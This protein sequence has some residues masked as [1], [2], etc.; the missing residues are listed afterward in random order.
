V[1]SRANVGRSTFYMHFGGKDDLLES[2][3]LEMVHLV[4]TPTSRGGVDDILAFSLPT[5]EHIDRHRRADGPRMSRES[6]VAMHGR[7]RQVPWLLIAERLRILNR[8]AE[9]SVSVP[10]DL[11]ARF[12]A[13]TFVLVLDWWVERESGLRPADADVRFRALVVPFLSGRYAPPPSDAN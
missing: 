8:R 12:V 7:L 9:S 6:R 5:F 13:S 10:D 3:I 1:I 11:V 2:G 4:A